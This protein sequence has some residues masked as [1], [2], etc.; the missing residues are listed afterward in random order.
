MMDNKKK[1]TVAFIPDPLCWT[2]CPESW[3]I[4][5]RQRNRW[6]RGTIETLWKHRGMMFNPKYK[7]LGLLSYPYWFVFEWLAPILEGGGM[8][9][10][11]LLAVV[12]LVN[13]SFFFLMMG[14]VFG[15]TITFSVLSLLIEEV[16]YH[17]YKRK[18]DLFALLRVGLIEPFVYPPFVVYSALLGNLDYLFGK[19]SWGEMSRKGFNTAADGGPKKIQ[20]VKEVIKVVKKPAMKIPW[21]TYASI[22]VALVGVLLYIVVDLDALLTKDEFAL[23]PRVKS[24]FEVEEEPAKLVIKKERELFTRT[25]NKMFQQSMSDSSAHTPLGLLQRKSQTGPKYLGKSELVA[26]IGSPKEEN[27]LDSK[28]ISPKDN[29]SSTQ[30]EVIKNESLEVVSTDNTENQN[31]EP[32][33]FKTKGRIEYWIIAASFDRADKAEEYRQL[34]DDSGFSNTVIIK[35]ADKF[36]VAFA[37]FDEKS[38][39]ED[40]LMNIRINVHKDAWIFARKN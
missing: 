35:G 16:T 14:L 26:I 5:G 19:S 25:L 33:V 39:A 13:W 27:E 17:N 6:T 10:F 38:R 40:Y 18:R 21:T 37:V 11:F 7:L 15:F 22:G 9:L 1:Y 20:V 3:T 4:L 32:E 23:S 31:P 30:E 8:M 29:S 28:P 36:R 2:E 24:W 12:G 34:L